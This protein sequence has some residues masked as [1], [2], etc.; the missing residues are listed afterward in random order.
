M[1]LATGASMRTDSMNYAVIAIDK[2]GK[3]IVEFYADKKEA[4]SHGL[5]QMVKKYGTAYLFEQSSKM[6]EGVNPGMPKSLKMRSDRAP[7][8]AINIEWNDKRVANRRAGVE[9]A[10]DKERSLKETPN[11]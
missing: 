7:E 9:H 10:L 1:V 2:D 8:T 3:T 5:G 11:E 4:T 6:Y